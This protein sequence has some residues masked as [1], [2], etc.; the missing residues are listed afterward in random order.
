MPKRVE[1]EGR[2]KLRRTKR[3]DRKAAYREFLAAASQTDY[4]FVAKLAVCFE[5]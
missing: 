1:T 4:D 5:T 2:E 3:I